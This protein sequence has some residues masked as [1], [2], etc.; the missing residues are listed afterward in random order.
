MPI[1]KPISGH[2][3]TRGVFRYLTRGGR[4]LATDYLNMGEPA[5]G[6]DGKAPKHAQFDWSAVM[7]RTRHLARNDVA[8]RG[9]RVRT[10]K[11]YVVSPDPQDALDLESLRELTMAWV[12]EHF[13]DFEVAALT[14]RR[15]VSRR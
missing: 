3:S 8:W 10:Y 9:N 2:T 13:S 11:H 5:V 12:R 4:A 6:R 1:V 7:D 15:P 14:P